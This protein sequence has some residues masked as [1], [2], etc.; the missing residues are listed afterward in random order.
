ME[1][2]SGSF[3]LIMLKIIL[4]SLGALFSTWP[5]SRKRLAVERTGLKFE[6]Q[7]ILVL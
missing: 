3:D 5:A 4:A 2:I 6:T 7:G 1:H